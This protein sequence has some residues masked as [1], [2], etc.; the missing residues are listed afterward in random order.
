MGGGAVHNSTRH[1]LSRIPLRWM[2]RQTFHCNTGITFSTTALAETGLDVHTLWPICKK[3]PRPRVGPEEDMIQKYNNG[4]LEP[5]SWR[6][7]ALERR[8]KREHDLDD[9]D[10]GK[11]G[12]EDSDSDSDDERLALKGS[13]TP[14]QSEDYFDCFAAIND[15]LAVAKSWWL[16]ECLPIKAR[17]Q[18]EDDGDTWLKKVVMN[19]GMYRPVREPEPRMHWT[20]EQ[21]QKE[22]GYRIKTRVGPSSKWQVVS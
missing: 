17:V 11:H 14:E 15:Q 4:Q 13:W 19:K 20:V 16:L 8:L 18:H 12:P 5:L 3:L 9:D 7:K 2:I 1:K 10:D 21:R 22:Q 6:S